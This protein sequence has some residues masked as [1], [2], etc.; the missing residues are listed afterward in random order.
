MVNGEDKH[1]KIKLA[2]ESTTHQSHSKCPNTAILIASFEFK[3]LMLRCET[4]ESVGAKCIISSAC[5]GTTSTRHNSLL[6]TAQHDEILCTSD[7]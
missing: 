1:W 7:Q 6:R 4:S 3:I 2:G 5:D